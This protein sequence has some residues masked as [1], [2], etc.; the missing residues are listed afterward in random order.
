MMTNLNIDEAWPPHVKVM[1][2]KMWFN[3]EEIPLDEEGNLLTTA[4]QSKRIDEMFCKYFGL[5]ND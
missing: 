3:G 4:A 1:I 2:N 5:K